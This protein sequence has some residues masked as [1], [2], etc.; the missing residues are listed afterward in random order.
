VGPGL[1]RAHGEPGVLLTFEEPAAK[2]AANVR[3]LGFD[4]DALQREGLLVVLAFQVDPTEIVASGEFDF[5][6]L[7]VLLGDAIDS[8]GAKRVV[9][10]TIE[11]LF[12]AFGDDVTVR[13]E[14]TRLAHWMEDRGSGSP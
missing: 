4:L 2:V 12:G 7:F 9:L 8:I 14:L 3:S 11:V 5:E 1:A 13:G 6:P 10:D